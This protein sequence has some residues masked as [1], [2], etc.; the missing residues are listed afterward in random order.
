MAH[1]DLHGDGRMTISYRAPRRTRD[2]EWSL[3]QE[4]IV[5]FYTN[6]DMTLREIMDRMRFEFDFTAT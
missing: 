2:E 3:H 6:R 5:E 1:H 4:K